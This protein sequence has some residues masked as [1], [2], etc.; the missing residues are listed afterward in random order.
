LLHALLREGGIDK[1][2]LA[3][4]RGKWPH[5]S[6]TVDQ[7]L[8]KE[9]RGGAALVRIDPDGKPA[10]SR[11]RLLDRYGSLAS[12]VEVEIPTGRTHQIRVHAAFLGNPIAG[13]PQYGDA[14]FNARM[15]SK[16]LQRMFLHAH[17]L[18]FVWPETGVEMSVSAPLPDELREVLDR[19]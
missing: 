19:L 3:L 11:F 13:D 17:A 10:L 15:Q 4:V 12:F 2:Y 7:P 8:K 16:G 14:D 1:R 9:R 5:G 6:V 18:S